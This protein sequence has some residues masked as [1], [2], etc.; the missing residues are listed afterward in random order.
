MAR[1]VSRTFQLFSD[2]GELIIGSNKDG[3][4]FLKLFGGGSFKEETS[5]EKKCWTVQAWVGHFSSGEDEQDKYKVPDPPYKT[6]PVQNLKEEDSRLYLRVSS[7]DNESYALLMVDI[8]GNL[9]IKTKGDDRKHIGGDR[10]VAT[11]GTYGEFTTKDKQVVVK[12][13]ETKMV[14]EDSTDT[15]TKSKTINIIEDLKQVISGDASISV[16]GSFD[17]ASMDSV[18]LGS[19]GDMNIQAEDEL[20]ITATK[21]YLN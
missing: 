17:M 10:T 3:K 21:I 6:H 11:D 15:I 8:N 18:S 9:I 14:G 13:S 4:T 16:T 1:L 12:K 19:A 5:P 20:H 2:F 7:S